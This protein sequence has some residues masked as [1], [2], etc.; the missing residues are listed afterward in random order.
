MSLTPGDF[1][2]IL[3]WKPDFI[4]VQNFI[5]IF[6]K[7][8]EIFEEDKKVYSKPVVVI[9]RIIRLK[10]AIQSQMIKNLRI[11]IERWSKETDL[12]YIKKSPIKCLKSQQFLWRALLCKVKIPVNT[13][14]KILEILVQK[15]WMNND[16]T[17]L[18]C[19]IMG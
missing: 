14:W 4:I 7:M 18:W 9:K 1:K 19:I 16:I 10:W 3:W 15:N 6:N 13:F 11:W 5:I 12:K 8:T 17:A 2:I